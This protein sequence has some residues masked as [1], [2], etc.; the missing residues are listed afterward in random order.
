MSDPVEP[1][2]LDL[3]EW[4]GAKRR[5][6]AEVLKVWRTSCPRLPVWEE[7][8][9]RGYLDVSRARGASVVSVSARGRSFLCAHRAAER[10]RRPGA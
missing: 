2:I 9:D 7:A 8:T 5:P 4:V 6:Y 3:L 10:A 1:L